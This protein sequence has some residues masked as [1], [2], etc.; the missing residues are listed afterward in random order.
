MFADYLEGV[1]PTERRALEALIEIVCAY[2]PEAVTGLAYGMPA[3]KY[4]DRPLIGFSSNRL[5][6]NLYPF[7]PRIIAALASELAEF[8]LGKG[9]IRFT[10]EQPVP[11]RLIQLILEMRLESIA[12]S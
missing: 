12:R 8:E 3:L 9:V 6:L 5:G 2:V 10:P 11:E 1:E 4:R 7:D